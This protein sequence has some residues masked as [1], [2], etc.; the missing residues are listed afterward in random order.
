MKKKE[1]HSEDFD[2]QIRGL[3][4][5]FTEAPAPKNWENIQSDL[6]E[7]AENDVFDSLLKG[8]FTDSE[9]SPSPKV[10]E[11]V[12]KELPL[13]LIVR[14]Q[15]IKLSRVAAILLFGMIS[16]AMYDQFNQSGP[17]A[18]V[19]VDEVDILAEKEL[20]MKDK[21]ISKSVVFEM[22]EDQDESLADDDLEAFNFASEEERKE[23]AAKILADILNEEDS[24]DQNIDSLKVSQI[25]EP[26][27]NPV[28]DTSVT[29]LKK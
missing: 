24:D 18:A 12:K 14:T 27:S 4:D 17:S 11:N 3:F 13:H 28:N 15:L 22:Q 7:E 16:F 9:V 21:G 8:Q 26:A 2:Q 23:Y 6:D 1:T 25:L 19:V 20:E 29:S 10:W 5:G